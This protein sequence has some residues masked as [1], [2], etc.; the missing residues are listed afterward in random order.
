MDSNSNR[1]TAANPSGPIT[2]Q[3]FQRFAIVYVRQSSTDQVRTNVGSTAA[4][5]DL[6]KVALQLGWPESRVRV[7]DSDLGRSGTSTSG[8]TGYLELCALMDR[9]EVGIVLVQD[10][11]RLGRKRSDI[12]LFQELA[13]ERDV[14]IYTTERSTIPPL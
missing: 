3:H 14:L 2:A 8:R 5:R 4:Q 10:L 9:D 11:S 7:I 6:F 12:A 1:D 13:E